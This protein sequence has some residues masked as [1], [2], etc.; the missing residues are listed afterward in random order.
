MRDKEDSHPEYSGLVDFESYRK[1]ELEWLD[2]LPKFK[3]DFVLCVTSYRKSFRGYWH[4]KIKRTGVRLF[5]GG[6]THRLK[7]HP[8][9]EYQDYPVI[10]AGGR[11]LNDKQPYITVC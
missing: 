8:K 4:E 11:G 1:K 7:Y 5:I 9:G 3:D 10:V 6:H 2:S